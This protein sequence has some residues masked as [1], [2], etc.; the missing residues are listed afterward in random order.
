MWAK[1]RW[2]RAWVVQS[3]FATLILDSHQNAEQNVG[4]LQRRGYFAP[5]RYITQPTHY[6]P[7]LT[8]TNEAD[9]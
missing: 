6:P 3:D 9:R 4:T 8:Q 1:L 5:T 2:T 7:L